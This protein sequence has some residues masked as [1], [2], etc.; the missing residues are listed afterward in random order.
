MKCLEEV[1]GD[2]HVALTPRVDDVILKRDLMDFGFFNLEILY[3]DAELCH[4][5]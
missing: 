1:R 5:F 2:F 4:S 3:I